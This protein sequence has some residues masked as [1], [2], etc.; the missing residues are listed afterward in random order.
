MPNYTKKN[1]EHFDQRAATYDTPSHVE[2][3]KQCSEAFLHADGVDW[4]PQ[5]TVLV[6]FACGTGI[7]IQRH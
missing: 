4:D 5:S 7:R 6:D 2:F 1:I 3:A